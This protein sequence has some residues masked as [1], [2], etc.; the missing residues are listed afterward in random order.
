MKELD[1]AFCGTVLDGIESEEDDGS[2]DVWLAED[3]AEILALLRSPET[4]ILL[5]WREK[6][7]LIT[8]GDD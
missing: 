3:S 8:F 2:E 5:G 1:D 6:S 4:L 7:G